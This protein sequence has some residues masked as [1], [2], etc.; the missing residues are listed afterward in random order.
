MCVCIIFLSSLPP[1]VVTK[2]KCQAVCVVEVLKW[3]GLEKK[4]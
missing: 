2:W 1:G 4:G 3:V